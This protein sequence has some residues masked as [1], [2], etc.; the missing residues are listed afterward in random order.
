MKLRRNMDALGIKRRGTIIGGIPKMVEM[1]NF[2]AQI[3]VIIPTFNEEAAIG[4]TLT[5]LLE[6]PQL[7][8]AEII[9]IDDGSDDK[10][11][12]IIR[13][14]PRVH[15]YQHR[16]HLGYGAAV[17]TGM[18]IATRPYVIWF[19]SDGQQQVA[20]LLNV[21]RTLVNADLDY[22]IGVRQPGSNQMAN[23]IPGKLALRFLVQL[24]AGRPVADF[25]SGL[26]GFKRELI[27][28][29]LHLLP[30]G[31]SA[32]TTTTLIMYER[33][34]LGQEIPITT[35]ER[36]GKSTV[37]NLSDGF[38][39]AIIVIRIL[40]LFKP[41]M[42]FG[43]IGFLL[44]AVGAIYGFIKAFSLHLGFPVF[45]SL[46]I[47]AGFQI[48]LFGVLSDQISLMRRERFEK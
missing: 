18:R 45:G 29:Y 35:K 39:T 28:H 48:L 41:F 38:K 8:E 4:I 9:V 30:K 3:S 10:T 16:V 6:E 22:C 1:K 47:I 36:I 44:I 34:H 33:N 14:L 11:A 24:T 21:A 32:S 13:G 20:D 25:N 46:L 19:D 42:F 40:L 27:L 15:L 12:E 23:R 7:S 17:T 31:F 2:D 5:S 43:S 26:R 37:R